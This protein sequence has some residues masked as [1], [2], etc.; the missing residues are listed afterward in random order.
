V[1]H[2]RDHR[3]G[4][5]HPR[6]GFTLVEMLVAGLI[7]AL[8]IGAVAMSLSQ[9]SRA[10]T[11][12]KLR[13]DAFLRAD[14]ALNAIRRDVASILRSDD[15]FQTRLMLTDDNMGALDRDEIL[16]FNSR[17]RP[18]RDIDY[19]GEGVE[20]ETQY[21]VADDDAGPVL[22]QRRDPVPDEFPGGG[23]RVT[24]VVEGV[25]GLSIEAFDGYQ[26]EEEWDSD[27]EGLPAA[28]RVTVTA[29]GQRVGE[30]AYASSAPFATLQTII[31]IDRVLK[32]V[33]EKAIEDLEALATL[34]AAEQAATEAAEG[35]PGTGE[36]GQ[37]QVIIDENGNTVVIQ[38]PAGGGHGG[39]PGKPGAGGGGRN[40]GGGGGRGGGG[41]SPPGGHQPPSGGGGGGGHHNPGPGTG[42][43]AGF[44]N[45]RGS[46]M[47]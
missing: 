5:Q 23:G 19:R 38:P 9:L 39:A 8:I 3:T 17:L 28:L 12:S 14:V 42:S 40:G 30:N 11:T 29:S 32:P 25:V 33:D 47:R 45:N 7:T 44:G 36:Q 31:P 4:R 15:L 35:Q 16:V 21:R 24:P 27:E 6:R 20:Y 34:A 2:G 43:G 1:N 37:P 22:W 18:I 41:G 10:K 46:R 13:L 26:W